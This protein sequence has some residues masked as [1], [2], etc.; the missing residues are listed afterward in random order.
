MLTTEPCLEVVRGG[1][2]V[3]NQVALS[4]VNLQYVLYE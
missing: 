2:H 3:S 4:K 1:N